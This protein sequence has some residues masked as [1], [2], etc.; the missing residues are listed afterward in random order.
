MNKLLFIFLFFFPGFINVYAQSV[1]IEAES[2]SNPGG[3]VIDQQFADQMGSP[4]LLAHGMGIPVKDATTRINIK[5]TGKYF[6][7]ARTKNWV[8]GNHAA[9]GRFLLLIDGKQLSNE[10]GTNTGWNW[11]YAGEIS[12]F[13]GEK[14]LTVHDLTGFEGRCD[15][16]CISRNKD[17]K[18]PLTLSE[19]KVRQKQEDVK[20][21]IKPQLQKFDLVIVG[22]GIAGCSAAI[23]AAG[24][25]MKVALVHDRPLL[26]GN[27]SS[28]VRVHTLGIHGK[29]DRIL[30]LI[31]TEHYPNGSAKAE[32]DQKKRMDNMMKIQNL[33]LFLNYRAFEVKTRKHKISSVDAKHISTG[34]IIRF[35]APLFVDCTGDGWIGYRAGADY[36]YGREPA[37]KYNEELDKYGW[38]WSPEKEDSVVMGSSLL[39]NSEN[40]GAVADFPRVPWAMDVAKNFAFK[41]GE[42]QWEYS[43]NDLNQ[44]EDAETIRD[45]FF[46]AIYGSFYNYKHPTEQ[47]KM[48]VNG[49]IVP[50]N[51][52]NAQDRDSLQLK[53]VAYQLGKRESR[54]LTGDYIYTFNDIRHSTPFEDAVVFETRAVD[55]HYQENLR[56]KEMPDFISEAIF[57]KAGMYS[58]PYRS[59]YSRNISN[60]F[61]AGRN[62][63]CSHTGLGGPRVMNT[64]GQMGAA[65]GIAAAVCKKHKVNPRDVY[66]FYLNE[67]LHLIE[68]Q[69]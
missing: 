59:L 25:G 18:L 2:F 1:F 65:V 8:P 60:L 66:K 46:R 44:I 45:H 30:K 16:I 5:K 22:G 63:S 48:I 67:Y 64:N 62:F 40:S 9:P 43:K 52:S 37:S 53:W 11:E 49:K 13:E 24:Q 7:W 29:F 19:L 68:Q 15:A 50:Y 10:L 32:N 56:D 35:E 23:A 14:E 31:D 4:Y 34:K 54:R 17:E 61:M 39:W 26:G 69:K 36:N 47:T 51:F 58:I 41:N 38:L 20:N 21:G 42:W 33:S 3:W 12:L 55:V 27:A 28:E 57:Y 6:V